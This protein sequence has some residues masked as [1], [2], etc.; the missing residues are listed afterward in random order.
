M[1]I[2]KE[3]ER[4]LLVFY[5]EEI[6][7]KTIDE[8]IEF[9]LSSPKF[10]NSKGRIFV[11]YVQI[12]FDN[13]ENKPSKIFISLNV[14]GGVFEKELEPKQYYYFN[15]GEVDWVYDINDIKD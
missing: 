2:L 3:V 4:E 11:N 9:A 14:F 12:R 1:T 10:E 7:S 6:T 8:A 13:T 15:H 5:F